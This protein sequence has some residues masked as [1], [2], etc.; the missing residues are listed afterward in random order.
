M[1]LECR[2]VSGCSIISLCSQVN[3]FPLLLKIWPKSKASG[4][5]GAYPIQKYEPVSWL[6]EPP[7][8]LYVCSMKWNDLWLLSNIRL[9]TPWGSH[10]V[11][12][13]LSGYC[14]R[15]NTGECNSFNISLC[16]LGFFF[17]SFKCRLIYRNKDWG[18]EKQNWS[19]KCLLTL[20]TSLWGGSNYNC[21]WKL[22]FS[23]SKPAWVCG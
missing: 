18:T 3:I 12:L 17:L 4:N 1:G 9:S 10:A 23:G 2:K 8:Q 5:V 16:V 11:L 20:P 19:G 7:N 13:G 6:P 14:T 21:L 15:S 22:K